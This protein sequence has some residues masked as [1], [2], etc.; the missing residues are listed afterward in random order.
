MTG[1]DVAIACMLGAE[2]FG[3]AT[4]PLVAMGCVMMRVCNMDTCPDGHRH[5]ESRT[6]QAVL[7][8]SRNISMNFMRFVAQELREY[9]GKAG[10]AH[11]GRAG[12]PQPI[13][14]RLGTISRAPGLGCWISIRFSTTAYAAERDGERL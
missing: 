2:E 11:G 1:R 10:R 14:S 5:P 7:S 6:A 13:S 4:A 8:A 3:F 12:G 9:H